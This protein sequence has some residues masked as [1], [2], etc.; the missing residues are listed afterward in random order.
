ME[1]IDKEGVTTKD[2]A[3]AIHGKEASVGIGLWRM[4][5]NAVD[6]LFSFFHS[7]P[8][9]LTRAFLWRKLQKKLEELRK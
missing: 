8:S 5:M 4:Y 7:S 9:V 6:V 1:V 2:L 3:L